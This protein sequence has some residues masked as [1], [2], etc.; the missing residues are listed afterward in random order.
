MKI[1]YNEDKL[2]RILNDFHILTGISMS[3]I[4]SKDNVKI[5][6][7]F[8]N[9][10][11]SNLQKSSAYKMECAN[12]DANVIEKCKQSNC[13]ESHICHQNL[14]DAALPIEKDGVFAGY[15]LMGRIRIEGSTLNSSLKNDSH[16]INL[17]N[18]IPLFTK[19]KIDALKSLL[20]EI[21]FANAITIEHD[22]FIER[23]TAYITENLDTDLS[24]SKLCKH[25][26]IS[27]NRLYKY[28]NEGLGCTVNEYI[29]KQ[30]LSKA[31]S[32]LKETGLTVECIANSVGIC[33][34]A[35][36]CKCFKHQTG[37]TPTEYRKSAN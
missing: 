21:L 6:I 26:F 13:F 32:L 33:N 15:I 23:I 1:I 2:K 17:F 30:R 31:K 5:N 14:Y 27:R 25:F 9:D 10:F 37:V 3:F 11:C 29:T 22:P 19:D 35:Y 8:S 18:Q 7:R 20:S 24:V 4:D 34:Y 36:F 12:C 16:L 28:F